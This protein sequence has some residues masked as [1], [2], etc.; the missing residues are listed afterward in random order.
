[1]KGR[2][3]RSRTRTAASL[4]V[5]AGLSAALLAGCGSGSAPA[6]G[7]EAGG[8]GEGE[9]FRMTMMSPFY[10][11]QPPA[12]NESNPAFQALQEL[13]NTKL[14]VT[15]VPSATYEDKLNVTLASGNLPQ[16]IVVLNAK[17]STILNAARAGA[18]WEIGPYIADYPNL[19]S[20]WNDTI[21]FHT[22]IDGKTYGIFRARPFVRT[23]FIYRKDWLDKLGLQPPRTV[24]DIYDIAK[25]FTLGDPDGNGKHD[26]FGLTTTSDNIDAMVRMFGIAQGGV[27]GWGVRDGKPVAM[28]MTPEYGEAVS[29]LRNMYA[30]KLINPDYV[31]LKGLKLYDSFNLGKAGMYVGVLDDAYNR[32]PD[33]Y[34][35]F[36]EAK[37][38]FVLTLE[39]KGGAKTMAFPGHAGMIMFPK[40]SVKTE[41]ELRK[42]LAYFDKALDSKVLMLAAWGVEGVHYK[43]EN[44]IPVYINEQLFK[45]QAA[46]LAHLR[47]QPAVVE[48]P[49]D[50][51]MVKKYKRLWKENEKNGVASVIE[52]FI[53]P[54]ELINKE[55]SMGNVIT[56]ARDKYILGQIDEAAFRATG[57]QW[58]KRVGDDLSK[59]IASF[60][61]RAKQ[62]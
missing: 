39:G 24:Q 17:S 40:S 34:K 8:A 4:L 26:T 55:A 20:Y 44:G 1:M 13:T 56:D 45:D 10:N 2:Q 32:H 29:L 30:E 54:Q 48:W 27:N 37:L 19:K 52:S 18:F 22:S 61:E 25:A 23:G 62:K 16:A 21:A 7:A 11:A 60:L 36:P 33:L 51:E 38:D 43:L 35:L 58:K 6:P 3:K 47:V 53:P 31:T 59:E 12:A 50:H 28:H 41:Q 15:Y 14:Q 5:A 42:A 57:E 49:S 9:P 46:E